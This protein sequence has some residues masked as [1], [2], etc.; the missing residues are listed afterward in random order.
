MAAIAWPC[1]SLDMP[2]DRGSI[3]ACCGENGTLPSSF[4]PWLCLHLVRTAL[5]EALP[6]CL[7]EWLV[8]I[9]ITR[10]SSYP[11]GAAIWWSGSF[12][13]IEYARST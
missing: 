1:D 5:W 13:V 3:V 4:S 10:L 2:R 9:P 8:H 7:S 6:T 11:Q 12:R